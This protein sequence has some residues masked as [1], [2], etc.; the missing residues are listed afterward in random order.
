MDTKANVDQLGVVENISCNKLDKNSSVDII[1]P[2]SPSSMLDN[3]GGFAPSP[4]TPDSNKESADLMSAFTSPLTIVSSPPATYHSGGDSDMNEEDD[5]PCTPKEGVFDPFA[6]GPDKLMNAPLSMK[7]V[8]ESQS[9]VARRLNFNSQMTKKDCENEKRESVSESSFEDKQLL[10]AV[11]DSLLEAIISKQSE[12]ILAEMTAAAYSSCDGLETPPSA[13]RVT[14]IA[15]T[16]PGAP[17]KAVKKS[18]NIDLSL[19]RRLDFDF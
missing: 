1:P 16:C 17:M 4:I 19:C 18:R 5:S 13:P 3:N 6:P 2:S 8:E 11:Y 9:Y 10:E 12:D 7:H 15:D 14:G